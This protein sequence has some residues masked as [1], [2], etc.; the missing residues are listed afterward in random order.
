MRIRWIGN[1]VEETTMT[2]PL[3]PFLRGDSL[4]ERG[5]PRRV[6]LERT[7]R[8]GTL[9]AAALWTPGVLAEELVALIAQHYRAAHP[10]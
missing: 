5:L 8:A 10:A 9:G 3:R 7:L 1:R 4:S 6:F 2:Q